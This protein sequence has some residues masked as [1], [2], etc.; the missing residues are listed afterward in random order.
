MS[1]GLKS[2]DAAFARSVARFASV[3]RQRATAVAL[4]S[5]GSTS[6]R[7]HAP[8]VISPAADSPTFNFATGQEG[9]SR[10][11]VRNVYAPVS[12]VVL[13]ST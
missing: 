9:A 7:R 13:A 6:S 1:A 12:P 4:T 11:A 10:K 5:P 3:T 8:A 2:G